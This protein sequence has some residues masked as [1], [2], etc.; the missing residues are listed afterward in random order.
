MRLSGDQLAMLRD[1]GWL[2]PLVAHFL[3]VLALEG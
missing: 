1:Q 3:S 2:E